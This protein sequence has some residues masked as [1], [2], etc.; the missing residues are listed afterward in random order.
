V[1]LEQPHQLID[2]G[3]YA[4]SRNP[5]YLAWTVGSIGAALVTGT[6]WPL[7]LLPIVLAV[8]QVAV[9]REERSLERSWGC[10]PQ[11][12]GLDP[13]IPLRGSISR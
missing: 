10:A 4:R 9:M 11:L 5:T 6:A 2:N 13:P 8:T 1:D 12:Q 7:R 3:P